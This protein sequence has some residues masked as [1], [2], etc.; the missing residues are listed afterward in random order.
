MSQEYH[1]V[2]TAIPAIDEPDNGMVSV[3]AAEAT[4]DTIVGLTEQQEHLRASIPSWQDTFF[5]GR[6]DIWGVFD[7]DSKALI[8]RDTKVNLLASVVLLWFTIFVLESLWG[9]ILV[10][11]IFYNNH[12]ACVGTHSTRHLALVRTGILFVHERHRTWYGMAG[13]SQQLVPWGDIRVIAPKYASGD[14]IVCFACDTH[15]VCLREYDAICDETAG[16]ILDI[17]G[18]KEA[19]AFVNVVQQVSKATVKGKKLPQNSSFGGDLATATPVPSSS[20]V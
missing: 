7:F 13:S 3:A 17:R 16:V 15:S 8:S 4:K 10:F 1:P 19:E 5:E 11:F 2:A 9:A 12:R 6:Q 20:V 14:V 18:I